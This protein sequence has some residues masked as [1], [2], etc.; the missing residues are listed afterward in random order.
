MSFSRTS[1]PM[2]RD[3]LK[4]ASKSTADILLEN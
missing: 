3:I 1:R 4:K 2:P